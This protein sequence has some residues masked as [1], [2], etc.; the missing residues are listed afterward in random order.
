MLCSS[1]KGCGLTG[2]CCCVSMVWQVKSKGKR[3]K[4]D[5]KP[6]Q[7][8]CLGLALPSAAA[9]ALVYIRWIGHGMICLFYEL[10]GLY[11]P[12]CGSGRAVT[13]LL[14]GKVG[15]AFSANILLFLLGIPSAAV[16]IHE[17]LRL[18][19]PKLG[20]RPV[21]IPQW[22]VRLCLGLILAFWV[23]RNIPAFSFLAP[24]G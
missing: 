15:T 19:F 13:A 11:C 1:E 8:L 24:A 5:L 20:L 22:A 16:F 7:R 18:V 21:H 9:L 12:G 2:A 4:K 3:V 6:W 17:Y 14:Q 23:L 10:T